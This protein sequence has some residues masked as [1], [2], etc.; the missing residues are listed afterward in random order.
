MKILSRSKFTA[1]Q[2]TGEAK[3][4]EIVVGAERISVAGG[5]A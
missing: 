2:S 5:P 1:K 3:P 4:G